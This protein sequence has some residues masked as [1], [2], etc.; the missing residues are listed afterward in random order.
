MISLLL[1]IALAQTPATRWQ[2]VETEHFRFIFPESAAEW[3]TYAAGTMEE[4]KARVDA[5]VGWSP[6]RRIDVVIVDP[7]G[8]ANGS[9]WP[10][11]HN[12]RML[13]WA[14]PPGPESGIGHYRSWGELLLTHEYAHMVHLLRSSRS[15]LGR[16]L[17]DTVGLA[18]ISRK[19]PRWCTEGYATVVEGRLSGFG[20]P[21]TD[22]RALLLRRLAQAGKL[23]TYGELN[24]FDRFSGGSFAYLVG[25]AYLEWLERRA[26]EGKLRDL[27]ARLTARKDR[28]FDEAF[29]GV[30][31]DPPEV[32]YARFTAE[33]TASAMAVEHERPIDADT[34]WNDLNYYT[35][36]PAVAPDGTKV[37][38]VVQPLSKPGTL[39]VW[40]LAEP[41]QEA[42]DERAE[43]L[44]EA[45]EKD[46]EDVPPVEPRHPARK[47]EHAR[48]RITRNADEPRWMP[49][50]S[51][52][53]FTS[54]Q[55]RADGRMGP[56]LFLWTPDEGERRVT[57][58]ADV[59]SADPFPD[60]QRAL[61]IRQDWGRTHLVIVDLETGAWESLTEPT[62]TVQLDQPRVAPVGERVAWL[63]H[64]GDGWTVV[65]HDPANRTSWRIASR[66]DGPIVTSLAW[67][68]DGKSLYGSV[69]EG[70]FVEVHEL[71]G[72]DGARGQLTRS[73]GGGL[74]PSASSDALFY[75]SMDWDGLELHRLPLDQVQASAVVDG[76]V[77]V[78]RPE[79]VAGPPPPVPLE[80]ET[81]PYGLGPTE[82]RPLIGAAW[83]PSQGAIE[84]GLRVGDIVGRRDALLMASY[85]HQEGV[86]GGLL[87]LAW[88]GLPVELTAHGYAVIDPIEAMERVGGLFRL[89]DQ[90]RAATGAASFTLAGSYDREIQISGLA[91]PPSDR[92]VGHVELSVGAVEASRA[93]AR[94][95]ARL[96]G[97][98]GLTDS[99]AWS[100]GE[101]Q[102]RIR[103]GRDAGVEGAYTL[104]LSDTTAS[105]DRYRLGGVQTS[106]LPDELQWSRIT[107]P[108]FGVGA[109]RGAHHE[110]V[111]VTVGQPGVAG[112]LAERH[113][114]AD[115]LSLLG[116]H[117]ST[118]LSV[119]A[120]ARTEALPFQRIPGGRVASGL[121]CR[122][123][124][125]VNGWDST[126]CSSIGDYGLWVEVG[127]EL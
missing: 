110:E 95:G 68:P 82:V 27:W 5:E 2:T 60:G 103:L 64:A 49:D 62:V 79:W 109:D 113:R 106:V 23:P 88:R 53:L 17:E 54:W 66:P 127:W 28:N 124:D 117:G 76:D 115:D 102:G 43:E 97:Q 8:Q 78:V 46:P 125:P 16:L 69:G 55:P 85:G 40:S 72:E 15:P 31:G 34:L 83:S 36:A 87:A 47:V 89:D 80:V 116:A 77:P 114:L 39:T 45:A 33:V 21:N 30:F 96:R 38:A 71:W 12:P 14:T 121:G 123:E 108:I 93:L 26:G 1:A 13:L 126:P 35:G 73:A 59:R 3:G 118:A 119:A 9:A 101:A 19:A 6:P 81:N 91:L 70:G 11:V 56:D 20:R 7:Y 65:V 90:V 58:G 100:R 86:S 111:T 51:A 98:I 75:L 120:S 22:A 29:A 107:S 61:A 84:L 52:L 92:V 94:V 74:M 32:L 10:F 122:I 18:P 25:S 50:S 104:G 112:L 99:D 42:L 63:E 4:I 57:R 24:A 41:D 105:I 48:T 67:S 44:K 37:A